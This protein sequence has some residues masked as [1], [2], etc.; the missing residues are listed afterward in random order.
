[1][2]LKRALVVV[3]TIAMSLVSQ[4]RAEPAPVYLDPTQPID[5]RVDDLI[6]KMTLEEKAAELDHK[7]SDIARLKVP[8]WGG[9]NQCL[10]GVMSKTRTTTVFPVSIAMGATW[11]PA[12]VHEETV[13]IS[14]EA[15]ALYNIH[16]MGPAHA[17]GAGV[18]R[19][20]DQYQPQSPLGA[21]SGRV[22]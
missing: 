16:A 12:L 8:A 14:D 3:S 18:S 21:N 6:S 5:K 13:A 10:H 20:G 7:A 15:R 17:G 22:W 9:W 1:M 4:A 2:N 11:D 19:A